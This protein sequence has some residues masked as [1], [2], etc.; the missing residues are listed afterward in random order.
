[1]LPIALRIAP[2]LVVEAHDTLATRDRRELIE[3]RAEVS[4]DTADVGRSLSEHRRTRPVPV[5]HGHECRDVGASDEDVQD[6]SGPFA[7]WR[8]DDREAAGVD[9]LGSTMGLGRTPE[10]GTFG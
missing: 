6:F 4:E 9:P 1:V 7:R 5:G 10:G 3:S 8:S 2:W